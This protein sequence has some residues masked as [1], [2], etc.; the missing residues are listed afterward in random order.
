MN[1]LTLLPDA[2]VRL[3]RKLM[4]HLGRR[5]DPKRMLD[6]SLQGAVQAVLLAARH[7][8]AYR[9]LLQEHGITLEN[10]EK[11]ALTDLPVL[12]KANT[13]GRFSL[14]QLA[15]PTLHGE[16]ADVLTSSGRSGRSLPL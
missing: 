6:S 8:A 14:A 7:S 12:T 5:M 2:A 4:L 10:L 15:R 13:F 3:L 1:T 16:V 9:T 11:T